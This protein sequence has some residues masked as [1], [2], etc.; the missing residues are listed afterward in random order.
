LISRLSS[1]TFIGDE[2]P[3]QAREFFYADRIAL[4]LDPQIIN[5]EGSGCCDRR[6]EEESGENTVLH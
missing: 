6:G 1:P 5:L 4:E 2:F 3:T